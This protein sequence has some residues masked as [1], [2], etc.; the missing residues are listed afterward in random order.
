MNLYQTALNNIKQK[1]ENK[2]LGKFNGIP[3]PIL[4]S[5]SIFQALIKNKL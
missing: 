2:K 5:L 4:V 3:F 1:A